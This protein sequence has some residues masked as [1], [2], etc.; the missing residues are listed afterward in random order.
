[1]SIATWIVVGAAMG[2]IASRIV[3][4]DDR[5]GTGIDVTVGILGTL[6]GGVL[7]GPLT[8]AGAPAEDE[9]SLAGLVISLQVVVVLLAIAH[10]WRRTWTRR[11]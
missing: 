11:S 3:R 7:L 10:H 5:R 2:W 9:F 8:R 4:A 1:M 6:I